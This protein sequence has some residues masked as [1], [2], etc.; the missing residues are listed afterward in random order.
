MCVRDVGEGEDVDGIRARGGAM[1]DARGC[2]D[3]ARAW[4]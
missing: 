3:D 4:G 2:A 1:D